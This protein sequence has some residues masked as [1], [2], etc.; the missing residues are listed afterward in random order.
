MVMPALEKTLCPAELLSHGIHTRLLCHTA[1][2]EGAKLSKISD[3]PE[4]HGKVARAGG[5]TKN[6]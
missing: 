4:A 1:A 3:W 6:K 2:A 5:A